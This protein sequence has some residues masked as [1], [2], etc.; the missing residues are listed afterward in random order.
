MKQTIRENCFET[1]SSSYHT[2]TVREIKEDISRKEIEKGKDLII[3]DKIYYK[4][5]GGTDSYCFVGRSTYEKAQLLIRFM[6]STINNQLT[7]LVDKD[8]YVDINGNWNHDKRSDEFKK[9]FYNAPI[10]EAYVNAIK[11]YIGEDKNVIIGFTKDYPP[12]VEEVFDEG[13]YFYEVIH[14]Q[15]E[16]LANVDKMADVFYNIIFNP[17]MEVI[18]ECESNG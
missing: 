10:V 5:I 14:V 2:L 3:S 6:G 15:E 18:E 13:A 12:F 1:N 7:E 11:R 17:S 8:L 16:D 9:V 4:T